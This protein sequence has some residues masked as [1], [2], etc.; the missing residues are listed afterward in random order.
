MELLLVKMRSILGANN[1]S[2]AD[3]STKIGISRQTYY[4]LMDGKSPITFDFILKFCEVTGVTLDFLLSD[5]LQNIQNPDIAKLKKELK[6]FILQ[7]I[8]K[9]KK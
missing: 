1:I 9:L 7:E 3:L 4:N 8:D 6:V 5:Y 2:V